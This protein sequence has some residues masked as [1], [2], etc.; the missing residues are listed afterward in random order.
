MPV[1]Q[2]S[3]WTGR[4]KE[5]KKKMIA[6]ITRAVCESIGCKPEDV[7][8]I[9]YDIEKRNWGKQGKPASELS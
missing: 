5:Q 8:I 9:I 6:G 2:I 4:T 1:V 7:T 3:M